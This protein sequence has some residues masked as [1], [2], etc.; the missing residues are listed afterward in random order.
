M[1]EGL[2]DETHSLIYKSTRSNLARLVYRSNVSVHFYAGARPNR[3]LLS[4]TISRVRRVKS[5]KREAPSSRSTLLLFMRCDRRNAFRRATRNMGQRRIFSTLDLRTWPRVGKRRDGK[6]EK[7]RGR[8]G[9]EDPSGERGIRNF[10]LDSNFF[11]S[12]A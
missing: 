11:F 8:K 10:R 2:D 5:E 12:R 3:R 6:R 7:E 4:R 9:P 1:R